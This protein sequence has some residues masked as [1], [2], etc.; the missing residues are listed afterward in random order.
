M[1]QVKGVIIGAGVVGLAV[2]R[3]L[4][5]HDSDSNAQWLVLEQAEAI[6]TQTSSRNSE[7]IHAGLYYPKGSSKALMCVAG[8]DLLYEYLS[9][10]QLPHRRCGKLIVATSD[11]QEKTLESIQQK[12]QANGVLDL[13]WVSKPQLA[14]LEPELR[15]NA[16]LFSPS[17]GIL[18]SHAYMLSLQGDFESAGGWVVFHTQ[19]KEVTGRAGEFVLHMQDGSVIQTQILV[20]ASG[21]RSPELAS[22]MSMYPSHLAPEMHFAKGNYFSLVGR[23]PF[24]R[25]IYPVPEAAGLG[26]HLTLDMGGQGKFG[27][28]VEW[29]TSPEDL[30]VNPTRILAFE[31]AIRD[32]WPGLPEGHLQPAY[33]GIR[34]KISGPN[35]ASADFVIQGPQVHGVEGLVHLFG[36]ESPGL[37]SS[38][39]IAQSVAQSLKD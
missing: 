24:Q 22:T 8:R 17:T 27:P 6:G 15:A 35:Q 5:L 18:D 21:L 10:R 31:K 30:D 12:A 32:Y 37:T 33:A 23:C 1:D 3:H 2:A 34:P 7:V 19:L 39:A 29:V 38:L 26:V 9:Q 13:Q 20:N 14:N 28:D 36:I 25:L 11:Q 4:A 16:A